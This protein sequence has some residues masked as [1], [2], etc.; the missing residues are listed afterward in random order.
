MLQAVLDAELGDDYYHDDPTT[1]RIEKKAADL[2]GKEA[3][4]LVLS[5][6][7]G[8]LTSV[9][10]QAPPGT[11]VIVDSEAH[12]FRAE[13]GGLARIAGVMPRRVPAARGVLDP[14]VV[15]GQISPKSVLNG[16]TS[17]IC[18]ENTHNAG[19]GSVIPLE[20]LTA[21]K[22]VAAR[23]GARV[24]MDGARI[25]NAAVALGVPASE[26]ARHAD[27]VAFCLSKGLAC[28]LGA[29]VCGTKEFIETA[30]NNRQVIGGGMRQAGVIAAFGIWALDNMVERLADDHRNARRLAQL[31][32]EAGFG[33]D[34]E[35]IQTNIVRVDTSPLNAEDFR[36][37]LNRAGIDMNVVSRRVVRFV[38][39]WQIT[40]GNIET[41]GA[42]MVAL[43]RK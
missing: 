19:G 31:A 11:E 29:V 13:A 21:L 9:M 32:A 34:P 7:M 30:R 43:L 15:E 20:N 27:S 6:T 42:E 1:K 10:S 26:I 12:I 35:S 5:G 33:V 25:F 28:P 36:A 22:E 38:T 39:H 17:L 14:E 2:L 8:N 23:H 24:H 18:V 3:A 37:A 16:G 4:L 41:A 40:P